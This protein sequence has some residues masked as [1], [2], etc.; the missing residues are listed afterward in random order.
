MGFFGEYD[1]F[2]EDCLYEKSM[3]YNIQCIETA[4]CAFI[5]SQDIMDVITAS[6]SDMV[7]ALKE[8]RKNQE[9]HYCRLDLLLEKFINEKKGETAKQKIQKFKKTKLTTVTPFTKKSTSH[10]KS[11]SILAPIHKRKG[12]R[13]P[14]MEQ[15]AIENKTTEEDQLM[16]IEEEG[17]L[18]VSTKNLPNTPKDNQKIET[19]AHDLFSPINFDGPNTDLPK[20]SLI[21]EIE[22]SRPYLKQDGI[23]SGILSNTNQPV[24]ENRRIDLFG[25]LND[26]LGTVGQPSKMNL[27]GTAFKFHSEAENEN[28]VSEAQLIAGKG[29]NSLTH[30]IAEMLSELQNETELLEFGTLDDSIEIENPIANL[31]Y[32]EMN[33]NLENALI[34]IAVILL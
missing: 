30:I 4:V 26:V 25:A 3:E 28:L 2:G 6:K 27:T 15:P 11:G 23:F 22:V 13:I 16:V 17:S 21:K 19:L 34:L 7:K 29:P 20:A 18:G 24:N 1:Y 9:D 32:D 12:S 5:S 8:V 10:K 33:P 14:S 31:T